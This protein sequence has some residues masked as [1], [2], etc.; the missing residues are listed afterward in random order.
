M[1]QLPRQRRPVLMTTHEI[2]AFFYTAQEARR[3]MNALRRT[4]DYGHRP[5]E[6]QNGRAWLLTIE[7]GVGSSSGR[8]PNAMLTDQVVSVIWKFHGITDDS[9]SG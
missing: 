6:P 5:S 8:Y 4:T 7:V 2:R 3:A 1:D 9:Q